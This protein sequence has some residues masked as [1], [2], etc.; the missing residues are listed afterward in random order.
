MVYLLYTTRFIVILLKR[1]SLFIYFY[2]NLTDNT[3]NNTL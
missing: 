3:I 1:I 2:D